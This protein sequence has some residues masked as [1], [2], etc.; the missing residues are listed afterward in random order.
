MK[1]HKATVEKMTGVETAALN[2]R[3]FREGMLAHIDDMKKAMNDNIDLLKESLANNMITVNN[4]VASV[5]RKVDQLDQKY[6][7]KDV[8]DAHIQL[9]HEKLKPLERID[10][11][12]LDNSVGKA[13]GRK[14]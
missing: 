5:E 7:R 2:I 9:I 10:R 4:T 8:H 6:V 14:K 3:E 12:L 11:F 1:V 13:T